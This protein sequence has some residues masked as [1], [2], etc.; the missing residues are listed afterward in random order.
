MLDEKEKRPGLM[1]RL[2]RALSSGR[3]PSL[4]PVEEPQDEVQRMREEI[5]ALQEAHQKLKRLYFKSVLDISNLEAAVKTMVMT[6]SQLVIEIQTIYAYIQAKADAD[7]DLDLDG[8]GG[9]DD[10]GDLGGTGGMLN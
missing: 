6:Q 7:L 9:S 5:E 10:N 2:M 4:P 8:A 3:S 1:Q